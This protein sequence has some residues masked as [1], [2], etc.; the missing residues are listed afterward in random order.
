MTGAPHPTHV[1]RLLRAILTAVAALLIAAGADVDA[2]NDYDESPLS[3]AGRN[4]N[5]GLVGALLAASAD[6]H[7][8]KPTGE[9]LL[10]DA[11]RAGS[12]TVVDLLIAHGADPDAWVPADARQ[13]TGENRGGARTIAPVPIG[14]TP[15]FIAAWTHKPEI[16]RTLLAAGADPHLA[17]A[18][19]TSPLAAAAGTR[20]R[21]PMGYSRQLD[22]PRMLEAVRIA[23]DAGAD[24]DGANAAGRTAMHGAAALGSTA[25]IELLAERGARVDV[26]D[27]EGQTPLD[28]PAGSGGYEEAE[29]DGAAALLRELAE[30]QYGRS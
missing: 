18:D 4:G 13:W 22:T 11:A 14:A 26:E 2:A 8:V 25:L 7:A 24:V 17:A 30:R 20:G 12:G 9:T 3:Q 28:L 29:A 23:L 5:V 27:N 10:D 19:A 15:L 1:A 16:M 21:P 6:P